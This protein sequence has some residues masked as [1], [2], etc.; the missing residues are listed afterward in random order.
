ML[1]C[2]SA[3]SLPPLAHDHK[4]MNSYILT[5]ATLQT[6]LAASQTPQTGRHGESRIGGSVTVGARRHSPRQICKFIPNYRLAGLATGIADGHSRGHSLRHSLHRSPSEACTTPCAKHQIRIQ[7]EAGQLAV[8]HVII[9]TASSDSWTNIK[10]I[11]KFAVEGGLFWRWNQDCLRLL[12]SH[13]RAGFC[14]TLTVTLYVRYV[15]LILI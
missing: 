7:Q 4:E 12:F 3:A 15:S 8:Q 11:Q 14:Q 13:R 6:W 10:Y 2:P 9:P 1:C 5:N